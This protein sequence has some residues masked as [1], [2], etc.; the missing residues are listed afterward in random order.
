MPSP[1]RTG[2]R[3]LV[4]GAAGFI[5][6]AL[7][8]ALVADGWRVTGVDAFIDSGP[9]AEREANLGGLA[10]DPRFDLVEADL[11]TAPLEAMV[12]AADVVAHLAGRPGVR[13]SFGDGFA[14]CLRDNLTATQRVLEAA[15]AAGT[16][17]VVWA[18]SSSVYGDAGPGAADEHA[19]PLQPRSPYAVSKRACE[20]LAA[21]ARARGLDVVGL[22]YFTVYGPRQRRDM[23]LRRM[24]EALC[25]GPGFTLLG[26]GRQ[27]R[28]MTHVDDVVDATVRA[29]TATAPG[30][31][32]NVGGG[33]PVT[34]GEV[35]TTLEGIAGTPLP[36]RRAPAARGDVAATR[37]GTGRARAELGW[38]P[39][40]D[41]VD[42]LAGQLAWVRAR[43]R[44][45]VAAPA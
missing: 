45:P 1:E 17:R 11:V 2:R 35:I 5:G 27:V 41:L 36:L 37:A 20:D 25:G 43:G 24:C 42:G 39:R 13:T 19:T 18:S 31:L 12:A 28:D 29:M 9:R 16:G 4:T 44:E 6:S 15:V 33:E 34:L 32:Y 10:D 3:A 8:E 26:D 30:P 40:V 38:T 23:A 7:C 22:R 21:I 14:P